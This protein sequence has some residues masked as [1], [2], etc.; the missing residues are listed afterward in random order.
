MGLS[1]KE[2]YNN[3]LAKVTRKRIADV[4]EGTFESKACNE[5][6]PKALNDALFEHSWSSVIRRVQLV[7]VTPAPAI[8]Y[9]HAFQLPNDYVKMV[10]AY[11]SI[12]K[13]SFDFEWEIDGT[14]LITNEASVYIK[15]VYLP[16][17]TEVMNPPLTSV[18]VHKLAMALAYPVNA[19]EKR[20]DQLATQY[21]MNVLPR[22]KSGDSMESRYQ[23]FEENPW[24]EGMY[25]LNP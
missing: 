18:V 6:Y 11:S 4:D 5:L 8:I 3:A 2:L 23:E 7:E 17:S 21:E 15:Y 16:A 19:D 1:K 20:E 24:V 25:D 14:T 9:E 10:N 12:E 13:D 22:A